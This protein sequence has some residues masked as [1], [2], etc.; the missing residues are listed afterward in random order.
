[1]SNLW[2]KFI[3]QK[4]LIAHISHFQKTQLLYRSS[5]CP[6]PTSPLSS[7]NPLHNITVYLIKINFYLRVGGR[8]G[9]LTVV[10]SKVQAALWQNSRQ[11]ARLVDY[12][13]CR[14]HDCYQ[15]HSQYNDLEL[16]CFCWRRVMCEL[17]NIEIRG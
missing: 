13:C 17:V 12:A 1:M 16:H 5:G 10:H 8:G 6:F 9:I 14:P 7:I 4:I 15:S 3:L 11:F 2:T